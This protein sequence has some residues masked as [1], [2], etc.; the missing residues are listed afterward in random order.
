MANYSKIPAGAT[1]DIKP[2]QAHVSE[3][4][5]QQFKRLLDLSPIARPVFENTNAGRKFGVDREWLVN[6]KDIWLN[7]FNW[8]DCEDR[9]NSY[10]NFKAPVKDAAGNTI[11]MQFLALFSD[12]ADAVPIAFLHGWPGSICEFMDMLD[13]IKSK[14]SPK[15]LPYHIIV[16]SHAGYAY[17]SGPPL[18]KDYSIETAAGAINSLMVGLGF[19]SGYLV[20]GGDLGSFMARALVMSYDSCKGMHVNQM[21]APPPENATRDPT[22]EEQKVLERA[23][24]FVDTEIAFVFEQGTKAATVGYVVSAS[25]LSLLAWIGEK[26][27]SW[28]LEGFPI[29]KI[30]EA[31]TLYWMTDT[32]PRCLYH[33]RGMGDPDAKPPHSASLS[34]ITGMKALHLPFVEK[35]C[36]YS[37]FANEIIPVP[38]SWAEAS[39]N[40]VLYNEHESG[41]HFAAMEKPRELFEDV[42][43]YVN[44]AWKV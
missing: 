13:I 42:E 40:L 5:L 39:V 3:E 23:K 2:F 41:G 21:G 20:Q 36:G 34:F 4:R 1:L 27:L 29:E 24:A 30:L 9:I 17:S 35:P 33:N 16:P 38:R 44:V 10:P 32:M 26:I 18:D 14:Y 6:A 12:K 7:Q 28:T 25:P 15:D 19:G 43:A 31:V 11:D 37:K 22:P 8:R